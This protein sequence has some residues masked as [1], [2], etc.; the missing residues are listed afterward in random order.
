MNGDHMFNW[1]TENIPV[2]YMPEFLRTFLI[3][4]N[5]KYLQKSK[6]KLKECIKIQNNLKEYFDAKEK[7]LR[8]R[9]IG[10]YI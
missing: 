10:A 2:K 9:D 6:E 5:E 7:E 8:E 1:L 4:Q 3:K